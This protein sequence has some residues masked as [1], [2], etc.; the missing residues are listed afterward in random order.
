MPFVS[1]FLNIVSPGEPD[2]SLPGGSPGS[3]DNS[4]PGGPNYPSHG[5]PSPGHP[6]QGLPKPPPGVWPPPIATHPIVPARPGTPPGTIWPPV[7]PD[8]PNQGLPGGSGGSPDNTLPEEQPE[9]DN[10]LPKPPGYPDQGLPGSQ[11]YWVV[12]GIPGYGWRYIAVDP[13]LTIGY[14]LPPAPEPK[15]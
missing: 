14:P 10:T 13:S 3:P 11:T 7:N 9:P 2:N 15:G 12:A 5:L 8:R 6:S 1:G 4:L